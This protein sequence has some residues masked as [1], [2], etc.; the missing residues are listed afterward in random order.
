MHSKDSINPSERRTESC[1]PSR[2]PDF[3]SRARRNV[4]VQVLFPHPLSWWRTRRP[5]HFKEIDIHLARFVLSK[6]AIIGEPYWH[7][8]AAGNL[9]MAINAA[10]RANK[11]RGVS[12]VSLDVAMTAILCIALEGSVEA[13]LFLAAILHQRSDVDQVFGELSDRWLDFSPS[14][15]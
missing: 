9:A 2:P 14:W 12:L 7:L 10:R 6:S 5:E 15:T 8:A 1:R 13:K 4:P 3:L 11:R